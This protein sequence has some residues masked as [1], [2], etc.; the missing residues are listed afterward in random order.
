MILTFAECFKNKGIFSI[1]GELDSDFI[2]EI[3]P[4]EDLTVLD[5]YSVFQIGNYTIFKPEIDEKIKKS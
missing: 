5:D 4:D 2:S 3:L 1:F